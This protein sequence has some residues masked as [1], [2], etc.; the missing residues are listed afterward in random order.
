ME[1]PTV[2]CIDDRSQVL[3]LRKATLKADGYCV[4]LASSRYTAIRTLAKNAGCRGA[5]EYKQEGM[6][7][8]AI[9][10]HIK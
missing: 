1:S 5:T 8:E 3:T 9:A 7:V 4:K 2:L 10:Y 6:D